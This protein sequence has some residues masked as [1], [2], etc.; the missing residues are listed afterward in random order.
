MNLLKESVHNRILEKKKELDTLRPLPPNI[1]RKLQEQM[2]VEYTYNSNAIEGNTLTLRETQL[3]IEEG[4]TIN[5]KSLKEN[6]EAK[7]HPEAINFVK[8]L[9]K[10]E[11]EEIDILKVHELIF[12]GV[13]KN[14]GKYRAGQVRISGADFMPPLP[15]EIKPK[16]DALLDWLRKNPDELRPIEFAAVFHHQFVCLHP[17]SDGNG[18]VSR[19]LMNCILLK[20][21]YPFVIILKNDRKRYYRTLR[22]ADHGNISPFVN[23]IARCVERSLNLYLAAIGKRTVISLLEAS[24]STRYSQEYLSL[25]A[26]KGSISA[27][28]IGRKWFLTKESLDAYVRE[29]S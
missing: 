18:R 5:G 23:F 22:E 17:F 13:D 9:S 10:K 28:K 16:T 1:V 21:R 20:Y 3:V 29:N 4:I 7:N 14:A 12:E 15:Q 2:Q 11:I 24:K 19:L 25:L 8:G 26:R 27:A 6:M